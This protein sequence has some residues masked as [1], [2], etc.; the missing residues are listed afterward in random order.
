MAKKLK[1]NLKGF[2]DVRTSHK[3]RDELRKRAKKVAAAAGG[4]AKGFKVTDLVLER[5]RAAVS[6]LATGHA[7]NSNRKHHSL[8][9]ALDAGR[10]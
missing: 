7:L 10:D 6:V 4:E 5:N 8:I 9:R 3:V 1:L 2:E